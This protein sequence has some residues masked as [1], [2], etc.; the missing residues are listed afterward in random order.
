MNG[1]YEKVKTG[2]AETIFDKLE[3]KTKMAQ[4]TKVCSRETGQ[5]RMT[6]IMETKM[7]I[8]WGETKKMGVTAQLHRMRFQS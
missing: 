3:E 1:R 5:E 8:M 2:R 4:W 6:R 7:E